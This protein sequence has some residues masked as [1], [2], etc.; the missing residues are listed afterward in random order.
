MMSEL[1]WESL[2]SQCIVSRLSLFAKAM[3]LAV[4]IPLDGVVR[5]NRF[6]RRIGSDEAPTFQQISTHCDT[7]KYSF[8]P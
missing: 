3:H 6:T 8:V 7:F 1:G 2:Q 4:A 5:Q